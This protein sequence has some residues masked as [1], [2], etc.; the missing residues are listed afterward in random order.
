MPTAPSAH[1]RVDHA[2]AA[3]PV[4]QPGGGSDVTDDRRARS[5]T[6]V[7]GIQKLLSP[8]AQAEERSR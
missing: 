3:E 5:T 6:L 8:R 7:T 2:L 1:A 4:G